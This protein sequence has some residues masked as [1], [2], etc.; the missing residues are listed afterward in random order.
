MNEVSPYFILKNQESAT[1]QTSNGHLH[2]W[3]NDPNLKEY[4]NL[5]HKHRLVLISSSLAAVVLALIWFMTRT[6]IY[7]A[8]A[9][10]MIQPQAPQVL[11]MR[12]LLAEQTQDL[13]HDYYKTQYDILTTRSLAA[14]VIHELDLE[15]NPLF[16]GKSSPSII[17]ILR[18][19]IQSQPKAEVST[20]EAYGVKPETVDGYLSQLSIEPRRGTRLVV[21]SF[22]S[23]NAI[24]SAQ[25]ANAHVEAYIRQEM[26]IHS[27]T[28]R[29]AEDFLQQKLT[30]IRDKVEKSEA[31]L[32]DYRRKRGIVTELTQDPLKPEQGQ[33]LLQRL[34]ELNTE[35]S[36]A[37]GEK[38][39]LETLHQL[40]ERGRYES[41]PEVLSNPV[42]QELKEESAKLSTEYAS[43][44]NRFNPG[45]HPLDDLKARLD[46]AQRKSQIEMQGVA[47]GVE[48]EYQAAV[49][50]ETKL[51]AE[52]DEVRSQAM[53]LDDASLQYAILEREEIAN[54]DLYK[55]VL[56]RTNE[57]KV[58]SDV[59]TTNISLIDPANP[60]LRRT[61]PRLVMVLFFSVSLGLFAGIGVV[62]FLESLDDGFKS[63]D[64]VRRYLGLPSLGV[65]PDLKKIG[66]RSAYGYASYR[67]AV[68]GN[69]NGKGVNGAAHSS[70]G[71]LVVMHDR[72]TAAGEFYR[73]IRNGI[74][75]SKAGGAPRS[76]VI[77]S[78]HPG[79]GKTVTAI[80]VTST[81]AQLSGRALLV[82]TDLR[83]PRCHE[84]LKL[85]LHQGLTE[86][87]VG[88][89]DLDEVIQPSEIPGLYLLSA[90]TLPPNPSELLTSDEMSRLIERMLG[91]FEYV[92]FDAAPVMPISDP[93]GLGR[94]MEGVIVVA[95]RNTPR[96][97]V[98]EACHRITVA[99][100]KILGI[101]LNRA[102]AYAFPYGQYGQYYGSYDPTREASAR[103]PDE[104]GQ[105]GLG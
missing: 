72:L 48:T 23:P 12:A 13:E 69:G 17:S 29:D 80:N 49:A 90:G 67:R 68:I 92:C 75:Y 95:G 98:W 89:R 35:L 24:L 34:N 33:P 82:D 37:S 30:E 4:W 47:Q 3:N 65:I 88:K 57:L 44:S 84:L 58:S 25:I 31:A 19:L 94:M 50:Y 102:D 87:L 15:H 9:T 21:V 41:L 74:M 91:E 76:I 2:S 70:L 52:I 99:G 45:Y 7:R 100:G 27:Q 66:D 101:V 77:T 42:I 96:R 16:E 14:R 54:Q 78:A 85:K 62:M 63:G 104:S 22:L 1:P 39:K 60:P 59:P 103:A 53:A 51:N 38:I 83:R 18:N 56:E 46:D 5:V 6:P 55:Q 11:D 105:S 28:G 73:I 40:V 71:D 97:M 32:N 79:E 43:L 81:F 20:T 26:E 8:S 61:G 64:E 10:I 36:K 93:V 86:V